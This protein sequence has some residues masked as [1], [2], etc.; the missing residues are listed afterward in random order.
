MKTAV[1]GWGLLLALSVVVAAGCSS[2]SSEGDGSPENVLRQQL[3][4]AIDKAP[5][6]IDAFG[7]LEMAVRTGTAAD[8]TLVNNQATVAVDM[9]GNGSRETAIRATLT[10]EEGADDFNDGARLFVSGPLGSLES[11]GGRAQRNVESGQVAVTAI[12]GSFF[13][14]PSG[15]ELILF[16]EG[17]ALTLQAE[18]NAV[19]GSI[20]F[21]ILVEGRDPI[22]GTLF[23]EPNGDAEFQ[24]RAAAQDDSFNFI[25]R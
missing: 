10:F 1:Y 14:A 9:D 22:F 8:V 2:D 19:L 20:G 7:R 15:N 25:V 21:E 12:S 18:S 13:D 23:F 16:S 6:F 17:S 3:A 24:I 4:V 11:A 5:A